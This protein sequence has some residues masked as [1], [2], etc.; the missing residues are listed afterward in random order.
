MT[1]GRTGQGERSKSKMPKPP[2]ISRRETLS[3]LGVASMA[4]ACQTQFGGMSAKGATMT[5]NASLAVFSCEQLQADLETYDAYGIHRTGSSADKMTAAWLASHWQGLGYSVTRQG[6]QVPNHDNLVARLSFGGTEMNII[7]QPPLLDPEGSTISAPLVYAGL[8]DLPGSARG[9][10]IVADAPYTR[11]SS[12]ESRPFRTLAELALR[13]DASALLIITNGPTGK[14][15]LLNFAPNKAYP[16]TALIAPAQAK[17]LRGA[18]QATKQATL[19]IPPRPP[20]RRAHNVIATLQRGPKHIVIST[21]M[22]GWTHCAGERGPGIAAIRALS[23]WLPNAYP[24]H[25]IILLAASGH[26]L[27]SLGGRLF[28]ANNAPVPDK[29]YLW[30]HLGAGWAARDWHETPAGLLPL[31]QADPQR[32]LLATPNI[33]E[34]VKPAFVGVPGLDQAYPLVEGSAAGELEHISLAGYKTVFGLFGAHRRH[35][36]IDD[37]M[38]TTSGT[39]MAPALEAIR[40]GIIAAMLERS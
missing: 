40:K 1:T 18:A 31:N 20:Q 23:K 29:V 27:E 7:A 17:N 26:E 32:Y 25:S 36:I 28:L 33:V 38:N 16:R 19:S 2:T 8:A 6:F 37:R 35:H 30:V 9:A 21:P 14:A 5:D 39:L 22:S 34:K 10:I 13:N 11:P 15:A 3:I 4:T 12:Y 24:D